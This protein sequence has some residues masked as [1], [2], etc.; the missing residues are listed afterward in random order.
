MKTKHYTAQVADDGTL[1]LADLPPRTSVEVIV[2]YADPEEKRAA[3]ERWFNEVRSHHPFATMSYD[4]I[5][6]ALEQTR[7][8]VWQEKYAPLY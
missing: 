5:L 1:Q 6:A 7:E 4:E 8:D 3:T 2:V